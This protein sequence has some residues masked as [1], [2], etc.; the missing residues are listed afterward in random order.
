MQ[1]T[2]LYVSSLPDVWT[3]TILSTLQTQFPFLIVKHLLFFLPYLLA[4][5]FFPHPE[6]L[7]I[8]ETGAFL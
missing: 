3:S 6:A 8:Y 5:R 2:L 7:Y 4:Q 1:T